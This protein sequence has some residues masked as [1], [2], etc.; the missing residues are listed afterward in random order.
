M[1]SLIGAY[2][3]AGRRERDRSLAEG[4][5]VAAEYGA[6]TARLG[7]SHAEATEAFLLFRTPIL[8]GIS[9]W[10]RDRGPARREADDILKRANHFMDQV[11]VSMASAHEAQ[12]DPTRARGAHA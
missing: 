4:R 6:E 2:L 12:A 9:R 5:E 7:L 11:L 3:T 10:M 1:L 8:D